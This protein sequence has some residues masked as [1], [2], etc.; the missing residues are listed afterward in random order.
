VDDCR[1][2]TIV[3]SVAGLTACFPPQ[4]SPTSLAT[5][6]NRYSF[7][8][9]TYSSTVCSGMDYMGGDLAARSFTGTFSTAL[10]SCQSWCFGTYSSAVAGF[11]VGSEASSWHTCWCKGSRGS[12][13]TQSCYFGVGFSKG[14]PPGMLA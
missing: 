5:Y 4:S 1:A 10:E 7:F 13:T 14:E 8:D 2:D 12:V 6:C 9:T 3:A 11:L